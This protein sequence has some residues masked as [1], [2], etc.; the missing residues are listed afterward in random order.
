MTDRMPIAG[1]PAQRSK[2]TNLLLIGGFLVLL[3]GLFLI[4]QTTRSITIN[5]SATG[6]DGLALWLTENEIK[7]RNFYGR[8]V[9][10]RDDV[11][12]R[13]LP[14]FDIDLNRPQGNTNDDVA[15]MAE[16]NRDIRRNIVR[17]KL[18][19]LPTLLVMPKWRAGVRSTAALHP[20]LL[21][22]DDSADTLIP[23]IDGDMG[24]L[25]R[26]KER[27]VLFGST[28]SKH[29]YKLHY[30]QT[31]KDSSCEPLIGTKS[32]LLLGRCSLGAADFWVL[33]DPDLL[34]N[35][36]LSQGQNA[37]ASL[38]WLSTLA[39]SDGDIIV[40]V[41]T[42]TWSRRNRGRSQGQ[43]SWSELARFFE[44]PFSIIW[45]SLSV[46]GGLVFWRAWW[47]FGAADARADEE[48]G[49]RAS[50][51]VS[52]DTKAR[53]LRLTGRDD[54]LV[55]TY[56]DGRLDTLTGEILG[57]HRAHDGAGHNRLIAAVARRSPD[58]AQQL[59]DINETTFAEATSPNT[60]LSVTGRLDD[61]IERI[62]DEFGRTRRIG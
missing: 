16:T 33:A 12:L 53:L 27:A 14:L 36:G 43:R 11:A 3:V 18:N 50:R 32:A 46:L 49:L 20:E 37:E 40:D 56:I 51:L 54:V 9:L 57:V 26:D 59:S 1:G 28:P 29:E 19:Q 24:N 2:S 31:L 15:A 6:F 39:K 22:A 23:Q 58:L 44:Y 55:R 13:I 30:P 45:L 52:V 8:A 47:R 38:A 35:H 41:T 62:L 48:N 34:N 25:V 7:A 60:L 61:L 21:I 4:G 10:E 42:S 5:R 17:R